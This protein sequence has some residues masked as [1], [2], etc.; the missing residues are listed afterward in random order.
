[1][2]QNEI[3]NTIIKRRSKRVFNN[4]K[5]SK[6]DLKIIIKAGVWA[7][8]GCNNQEIRFCILDQKNGITIINNFKPFLKHASYFVLLM[9]DKTERNDLYKKNISKNL[10][11]IDTGLALGNIALAAESLGMSSCICNLTRYHKKYP[12]KNN[13]KIINYIYTFIGLTR[14]TK[15]GLKHS[16]YKELNIP[17]RY[18]ILG[19][20]ALGYSDQK[21]NLEEAKHGKKPIKRKDIINY[22]IET[23]NTHKLYSND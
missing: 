4:K 1:M 14:F 12:K 5:I 19:G 13:I 20:I 3:I 18:E 8:T 16:L 10:K 21:I 11:Y 15:R 9:R 7:P 6:E 22:L 17:K 2:H 23:E